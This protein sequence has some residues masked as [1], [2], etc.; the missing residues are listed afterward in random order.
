MQELD[1]TIRS[2]RPLVGYVCNGLRWRVPSQVTSDDLEACGLVGLWKAIVRYRPGLG[3]SF[4]TWAVKKIKE[5][6]V[7]WL[8]DMKYWR[9]GRKGK[10]FDERLSWG[11]LACEP[12]AKQT[13][14]AELPTSLLDAM[15][16]RCRAVAILKADGWKRKDV[17]DLLGISKS[18]VFE[19][20]R[21]A[22]RWVLAVA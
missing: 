6:I 3:M 8:R 17:A 2:F 19:D 15:P 14:D 5:E 13:T 12:I 21:Q 22:R 20:L 1:D 11:A 7:T 9:C 4:T 18:T 16:V 10:T